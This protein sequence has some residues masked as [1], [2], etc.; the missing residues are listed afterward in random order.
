M[1]MTMNCGTFGQL[2]DD[3][4]TAVFQLTYQLIACANYGKFSE[5]DDP[6]IDIMM[7]KM[8]FTGPLLSVL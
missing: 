3:E 8:G 7:E 6:S 5:A 1:V 4:I 2:T